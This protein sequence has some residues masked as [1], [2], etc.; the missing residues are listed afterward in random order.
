MDIGYDYKEFYKENKSEINWLKEIFKK[1]KNFKLFDK[2][3]YN[4]SN[5]QI[6]IKF[7]FTELEL[8]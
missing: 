1:F 8:N 7:S 5:V 2:I 6:L 3:L 4:L